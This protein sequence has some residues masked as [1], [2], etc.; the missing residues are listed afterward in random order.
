MFWTW[1][2]RRGLLDLAYDGAKAD[3]AARSANADDAPWSPHTHTA[4]PPSAITPLLLRRHR[5]RRRLRRP[6]LRPPPRL[7]PP[8]TRPLRALALALP[9]ALAAPRADADQDE[10]DQDADGDSEYVDNGSDSDGEF[11][12]PGHPNADAAQYG[13]NARAGY[14]NRAG[15]AGG[16]RYTPYACSPSPS[17][18]SGDAGYGYEFAGGYDLLPGSHHVP[19]QHEQQG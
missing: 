11:F 6:A 1:G 8:L 14:S 3:V 13:S 18:S 12:P 2:T 15:G 17:T 19:S 4:S 5:P 9:G 7:A 16:R 10:D